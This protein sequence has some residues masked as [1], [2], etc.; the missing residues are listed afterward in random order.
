[1]ILFEQVTCLFLQEETL[2]CLEFSE[3]SVQA[4]VMEIL[5]TVLLLIFFFSSGLVL[6]KLHRLLIDIVKL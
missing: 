5:Y 6:N 1:M 4:V 2:A 3:V